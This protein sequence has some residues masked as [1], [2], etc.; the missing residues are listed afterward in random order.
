MVAITVILAAV[1]GAFV[2]GMGP[3]EKAPTINFRASA[4]N[5]TAI[6]LEVMGGDNVSTGTLSFTIDGDVVT[7]TEV[8]T[9]AGSTITLSGAAAGTNTVR[10]IDTA[11]N[12][13]IFQSDVN[14]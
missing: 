7:P 6:D 1:I 12:A 8:Y 4:N 11:S 5:T 3:G 10:V 2:F 14:V 13:V 9:T